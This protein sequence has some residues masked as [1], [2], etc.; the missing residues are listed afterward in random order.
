A[1]KK[2]SDMERRVSTSSD[3][4][5]TRRPERYS[6]PLKQTSTLINQ[7]TGTCPMWPK[8]LRLSDLFLTLRKKGCVL[9]F[10]CKEAQTSSVFHKEPLT[11]ILESLGKNFWVRKSCYPPYQVIVGKVGVAPDPWIPTK[12]IPG[13]LAFALQ[14]STDRVRAESD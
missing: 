12:A 6:M 8:T 14:M 10:E 5:K 2:A 11:G 3:M 1:R 7:K 13:R 9:L 4:E